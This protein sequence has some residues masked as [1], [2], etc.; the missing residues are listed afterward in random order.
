MV[1]VIR[2]TRGYRARATVKS[3]DCVAGRIEITV[4]R[5]PSIGR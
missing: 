5:L 1:V 2:I 3:D 4:P